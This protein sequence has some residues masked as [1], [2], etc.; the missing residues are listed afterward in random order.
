[1]TLSPEGP[2]PLKESTMQIE[3]I[4]PPSRHVLHKACADCGNDVRCDKGFAILDAKPG[5]Y[6]CFACGS[7]DHAAAKRWESMIAD[8]WKKH[9]PLR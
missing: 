3:P 5:T 4:Y 9:G 8:H 2:F 1:M 7:L 6:L